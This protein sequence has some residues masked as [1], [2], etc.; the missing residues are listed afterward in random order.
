[1]GNMDYDLFI[2]GGGS[3]GVRAARWAAKKGLKVGLAEGSRLGGTC[4]NVGCVPKKLFF[5]A[6]HV[7]EQLKDAQGFGWAIDQEVSH[8]WGSLKEGIDR[9]LTR[10]NGLYANM[11]E[12]NGVTR[13][14][15][16]A[17][18]VDE[19]HIELRDVNALESQTQI[20]SARH[21]LL[22]PGAVPD[23]PQV[24]GVEL[25]STSDDFFALC[26]RPKSALVIGGGYIGVEMA[27]VLA[28]LGV[29]TSLAFRSDLPLRSFDQD[30]RIRLD[31]A[32][33]E[34]MTVYSGA[35]LEKI[36]LG[37]DGL[38]RVYLSHASE[39]IVADFVLLATGRRPNS[40]VLNLAS[41]GIETSPHRQAIIVNENY[42][43]T[44]PHI[45]AV[46]DVIDRMQL[47]P[48]ALAEAMRVVEHITGGSMPPLDYDLVPTTV[49]SHPNLA[50]VG[51]SEAEAL[52]RGRR[53]TVY[54]AD[55]KPLHQALQPHPKRV[56]MKMI[57]NQ[58]TD[59][60]IGCHMIGDE[61]G[62]QIQGL[63]VA[64][65]AAVSKSQLDQTIGI[66]PTMAEEWVTMRTPRK[67]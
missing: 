31:Q 53:I 62:E 38:K 59:R 30:V 50:T 21:I 60:V 10:L 48:V 51:L 66:H 35:T 58:D 19:H 8:D 13:Y 23:T 18:L 27:G 6:A 40:Q 20:V 24:K 64:M 33:R 15:A 55:F 3:G 54:E 36:E 67:A 5:H 17:R 22:A 57:V 65:Q 45:Y 25:A 14:S 61:A 49:F 43:T 9:Y 16:W 34:Q 39:A 29:E 2:I 37:Q 56:Y 26:E 4:V 63:A 46:G 44:V 1:M 12:G 42:Q 47:T 7:S 28:G 52:R 11:L 41:V 32:L